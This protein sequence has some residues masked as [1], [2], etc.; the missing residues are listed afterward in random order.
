MLR[1]LFYLAHTKILSHGFI[2]QWLFYF[3]FLI[4]SQRFNSQ[5]H[6][7]L[8]NSQRLE[9]QKIAKKGKICKSC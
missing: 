8:I 7:F 6:L 2:W 5:N 9:T 1:L 4:N 3:L